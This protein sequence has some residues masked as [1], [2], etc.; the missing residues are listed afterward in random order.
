MPEV[1]APPAKDRRKKLR[2]TLNL[3]IEYFVCCSKTRNYL[4]SFMAPY[5]EYRGC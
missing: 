3:Q 4:L 5:T 2:D 1:L